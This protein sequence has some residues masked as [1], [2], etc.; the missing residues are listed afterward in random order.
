MSKKSKKSNK[1]ER[2]KE[3]ELALYGIFRLNFSDSEEPTKEI[4]ENF[5]DD[6]L[7][8]PLKTTNGTY[9]DKVIK[10]YQENA[11]EIDS[12]ISKYLS[13][14]WTLD[15]IANTEKAI[16]Q[17]AITEMLFMDEPVPVE[18]AINEAVEL[19]KKYGQEKSRRYINGLL[20]NLM[21]HEKRG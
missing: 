11:E 1:I 20:S 18:I 13:K 21:D 19:S 14:G 4:I 2:R 6:E 7:L 16:M 3:R 12:L 17:V 9:A 8:K 15:S 10:T 5:T